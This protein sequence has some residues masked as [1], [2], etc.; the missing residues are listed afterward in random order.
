MRIFGLQR[1]SLVDYPG[2]TACT[3]FTGGCNFRCPFCHN[4]ALVLDPDPAEALPEAEI[5]AFLEKR[6]GLLDGVCVSGGEPLLQKDLGE[7]LKSVKALG[8]PVKLDTNG[9]FPDLL[10]ALLKQELVDYVAMD[11]KNTPEKYGKTV[12]LRN[13]DPGPVLESA[14]LL[15]KGTV[16]F[17]FRTTVVREFHEEEDFKAIGRWLRG[18][19]RYYLQNFVASENTIAQGLHGYTPRE[20]ASF[21]DLAAPFFQSVELRG[22]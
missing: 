5:R 20:L 22:I 13:F 16:P 7:F 3:V 19:P 14:A 1:L 9:S 17:E 21:R 4:S 11:I 2:K 15:M 8:Y 10:A 12:G 6:A 18:A